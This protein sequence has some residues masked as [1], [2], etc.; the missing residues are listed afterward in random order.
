VTEPLRI[1][2][3]PGSTR[4][5]STNVAALRAVQDAAS[6]EMTTVMFDRL[7]DLPAFNPDDDHDPL[8]PP[9]AALRG[10]IGRADGVLFCTPEYAGGLPGSFKNL[11]DWTV[12]GGEMDRKPV[13]W[14]NVAPEGRGLDAQRS[15]KTVLGYLGTVICEPA[16]RRIYVARDALDADGVIRD[17]G[18]RREIADAL[19]TFAAAITTAAD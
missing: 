6:G 18:V 11:L 1:L 14:I 2:L 16:G 13:A 17:E 3:V 9:V 7:A 4:R 12:G 19:R 5:G 10:E 15:L 8:P